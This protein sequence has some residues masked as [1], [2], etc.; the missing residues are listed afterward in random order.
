MK[1]KNQLILTGKVSDIGEPLTSNIPDSYRTGLEL[2]VGWK[3][4]NWLK[5]SGNAT[6][7]SNKI[8]NFVEEDIEMYDND[9]DWNFVGLHRDSLGTTDIAYSPNILVGSVFTFNYKNF[10]AGLLSNFVGRQYFDNTSNVNRSIDPYF[11][12][13][14]SLKYTFKPKKISGIDLQLLV[15]NLFNAQYSN[16]AYTWYS[17]YFG[18]ERHNEIRFFPQAGINFLAGITFRF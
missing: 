18:N 16:N 15:N 13:N 12:N 17:C 2:V 3:I 8:L 10:E 1:Y 11:V 9:N 6:F 7:S 4:T 5:W 14:L